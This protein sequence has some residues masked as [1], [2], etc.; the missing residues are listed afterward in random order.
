MKTI[1]A[2][3]TSVRLLYSEKKIE[4]HNS[5]NSIDLVHDILELLDGDNKKPINGVNALIIDN[6]KEYT[7]TMIETFSQDVY[8][9]N[10]T[11]QA[12]LL[13]FEN[14]DMVNELISDLGSDEDI[15]DT[16][17]RILKLRNILRNYLKEDKL[18]RLFSRLS[19]D[20]NNKRNKIND[21]SK[22]A[23]EAEVELAGISFGSNEL[24]PNVITEIDLSDIDSSSK[25]I[26]ELQDEANSGLLLE[27]GF[28][29]LN[30]ALDGG[31]RR[32]ELITITSQQ[33][34]YKSGL[35]RSIFMQTMIH[36]K[37][38]LIDKNKKPL[39][40]FISFEDNAR[41]VLKFMYEYLSVCDGE[42]NRIMDVNSTEA[43]KLIKDRLEAFGWNVKLLVVNPSGWGYKDIFN[44]VEKYESKGYEVFGVGLDYLS[45]LP[46]I[47]CI[48]NGTT[49][50]D[51]RDLFRRVGNYGRAKDIYFMTPH[52]S[53]SGVKMLLRN[54]VG[55]IDL[56]KEVYAK[57][58]FADSSQLD[59]EQDVG[60]LG[61][62]VKTDNGIWLSMA[63]DKHRG[64]VVDY[65]K[66]FFSYKFPNN[67]LPI[68]S[69]LGGPHKYVYD[70]ENDNGSNDLF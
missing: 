22:F 20:I 26:H 29:A 60:I 17:K 41:L 25:I 12:L 42:T 14:K 53:S 24:D 33:H 59:Q 48:N 63:V 10:L 3:L 58:Y 30:I 56:L 44:T 40:I 35:T 54:G 51:T 45:L 19:F 16:Q 1:D 5:S 50:S 23:L 68:A 9:L 8:D 36:N 13:I 64:F 67:G 65:T 31:I 28:Q 39:M 7:R 61:H 21:I 18:R 27:T 6:L 2:L 43:G 15:G 37:P 32:G 66:A 70:L 46:K 34:K 49:G 69:D 38:Q 57:G 11:K 47:G 4:K 55:D 62:I 52:Q